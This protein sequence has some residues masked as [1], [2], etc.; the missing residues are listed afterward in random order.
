E[1]VLYCHTGSRSWQAAYLLE[2]MGFQ[3]VYN[4]SGGI[5]AWSIHVDPNMPRY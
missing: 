4:L 5:E 3:Q 2:R 1:Y